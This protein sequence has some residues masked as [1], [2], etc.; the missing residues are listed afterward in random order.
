MHQPRGMQTR[1]ESIGDHWEMK[2]QQEKN[3]EGEENKDQEEMF[4]DTTSFP[5]PLLHLAVLRI[6]GS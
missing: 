1:D 3:V 4:S 6:S 5:F 2:Q